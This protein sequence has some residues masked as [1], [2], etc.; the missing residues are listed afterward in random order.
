MKSRALDRLRHITRS[1]DMRA[2]L[3]AFERVSANWRS[4]T[5]RLRKC[6]DENWYNTQYRL[7]NSSLHG[8]HHYL[9]VGARAGYSPNAVFNEQAYLRDNEDVATAVA[10]GRFRCGFEHYV[11][12][13]ASELRPAEPSGC[14]SI[15]RDSILASLFD[16]HWYNRHYELEASTTLKGLD[17]YLAVGARAGYSPNEEFDE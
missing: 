3:W 4:R 9:K 1:L 14:L 15:S 11:L 10:Q 5:A 16:E 2:A 8:F 12:L 17:H 13:G 6:F 7:T